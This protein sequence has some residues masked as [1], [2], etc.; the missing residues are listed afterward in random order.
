MAENNDYTMCIHAIGD[1][2]INLL[3]NCYE[4]GINAAGNTRSLQNHRIEHAEMITDEQVRKAEELGILLSMQPNFLKWEYPGGLYETRLGPQ[5]FM[6]L[7]RFAKIQELG[8]KLF[9]G[10]D[11][12]PLSPLFGIQQATGFPSDQIRISV[13][14]AIKAYTINNSCALYMENKL[15]SISEGKF[16]DFVVLSKSPLEVS[17]TQIKDE[18]IE[19]TYVN[20]KLVFQSKL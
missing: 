2:A 13:L 20:G 8:A 3:L 5:R 10:S 9:F 19:K 15:G 17:N 12:M 7:N 4:K 1:E 16:A 18:L 11:N 14:D 6:T